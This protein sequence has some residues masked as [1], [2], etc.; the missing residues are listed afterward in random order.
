MNI[1]TIVAGIALA[2]AGVMQAQD[3]AD[4]VRVADAVA[5][6]LK[7]RPWYATR[8]IPA[9]AWVD[10][11]AACVRPDRPGRRASRVIPPRSERGFRRCSAHC[12]WVATF[13]AWR[14]PFALFTSFP[15]SEW[16]TDARS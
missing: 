16:P 15:T 7:S 4:K 8:D 2:V 3:D 14:I 5:Q 12:S 9:Q 13:L 10:T 1:G 6:D 11:L